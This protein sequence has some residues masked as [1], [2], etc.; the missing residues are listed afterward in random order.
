MKMNFYI[1]R[2]FGNKLNW[3]TFV[4]IPTIAIQRND[5]FADEAAYYVGVF[6]LVFQT[7]IVIRKKK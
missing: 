4:L 6:W 3:W 7:Y 1:D 5:K 2:M